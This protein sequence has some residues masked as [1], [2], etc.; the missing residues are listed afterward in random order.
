MAF[1]SHLIVGAGKGDR[2]PIIGLEGRDNSHYTMPAS[3]VSLLND[4][5]FNLKQAIGQLFFGTILPL[6]EFSPLKYF[7]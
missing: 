4:R 2:T 1:L 3:E 5:Y 6:S 7:L